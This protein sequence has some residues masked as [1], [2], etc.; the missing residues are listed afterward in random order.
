MVERLLSMQEV[1]GSIPGISTLFFA[2]FCQ[3]FLA[4]AVKTFARLQL[5]LV[6][7]NETKSGIVV[8]LWF[9][10]IKADKA[11]PRNVNFVQN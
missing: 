11:E 10:L 9:W 2:I 3:P 1:P 4:P 8:V 5:I 6:A 7:N